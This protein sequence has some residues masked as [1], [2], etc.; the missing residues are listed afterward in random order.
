M[1]SFSVVGPRSNLLLEAFRP[2]ELLTK[3]SRRPGV[4]RVT[5]QL[6]K[7]VAMLVPCVSV[8]DVWWPWKL[9]L[10]YV[11]R[12]IRFLLLVCITLH[13]SLLAWNRMCT[14]GWRFYETQLM[15]CLDVR[16]KA[17]P[18]D[19]PVFYWHLTTMLR[20]KRDYF[21]PS[22][23]YFFRQCLRH[24][25]RLPVE[26]LKFQKL[27]FDFYKMSEAWSTAVENVVLFSKQ[28]IVIKLPVTVLLCY[29]RQ[30]SHQ[31][32]CCLQSDVSYFSTVSLP[33]NQE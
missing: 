3:L 26:C 9:Y 31:K 13:I 6:S 20:V 8:D 16:W 14:H 32:L 28:C 30:H 7:E 1:N 22:R 15:F 12:H 29:L 10:F 11:L 21:S 23:H 2:I 19:R 4:A 33:M 5:R 17:S 27:F 25:M 24:T 18:Y